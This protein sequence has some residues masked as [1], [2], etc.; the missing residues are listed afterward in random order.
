M[1]VKL[2]VVGKIKEK[3]LTDACN[4]YIKRIKPFVNLNIIEIKELNNSESDKN[5]LEEGKNILKYIDNNDFV[6]TLEIEGK[7]L[8]S[9]ELSDYISKHYTYNNKV[10]TFIIGSSDG[11]S[12]EV[13]SRSDYKLSF[14]KMTFPHQLMRVIFLEQ[15]YRAFS[16]INHSKYHK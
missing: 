6:I 5:L 9:V 14:S 2:I 12:N 16:I 4:E 15:L 11:L 10:M 1:D 7:M 8:T 13:K 3:Y